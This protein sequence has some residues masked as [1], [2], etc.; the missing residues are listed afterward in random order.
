M[1][2]DRFLTAC[3]AT[4]PKIHSVNIPDF[5]DVSFREL[6]D[7]ER[8]SKWDEW[9][10]P[11]GKIN[12]KRV[13]QGRWQAIV[14]TACDSD[15]NSILNHSDIETIKGLPSHVVSKMTEV[16]LHCCGLSDDDINEKLKKKLDTS[17]TTTDDTAN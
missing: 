14:L 17:E 15:G 3:T 1:D 4:K 5:G 8:V 16:A 13:V 9:I 10:S 6:S 2:R 12:R 7:Y 11:E